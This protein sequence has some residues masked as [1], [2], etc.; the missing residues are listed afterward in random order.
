M[1]RRRAAVVAL[2][3][4]GVSLLLPGVAARADNIRDAQWH[5]GF[6]HVAEA[7][8]LAGNGN[9][10]TVAVV[11]T[12]VDATHPDLVGN[13]LPGTDVV[14]VGGDGH[15]DDN[16]HG[17]AMAGLI[18]GH[19][20]GSDAGA[21]GIAPKSKILPVK[22]GVAVLDA[23]TAAKGIVWA[24]QHRAT[25]MCLAFGGSDNSAERAAIE[26]ALAADIVLVAGV[27]NTPE[28]TV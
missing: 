12:G 25:V 23:Q 2:T 19:G 13:V 9:G 11:D 6:L 18:A 20:H 27:G 28:S 10:V 16:G 15:S 14:A 3:G 21:I 26:Q 4:V 17:T 22:A 1:R 7:Q 5:L 8:R 24:T